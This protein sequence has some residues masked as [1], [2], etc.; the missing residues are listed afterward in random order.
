MTRRADLA[1]IHIAKKDLALD[2]DDYRGILKRV[3]GADSA[4]DLDAEARGRVIGYFRRLGWAP[5]RGTRQGR[6]PHGAPAQR[7]KIA[8]LLASDGLPP[9]YGEAIAERMH[10]K[11][12]A[13][14][15]P[16]E[17]RAVIASLVKQQQR[18]AAACASAD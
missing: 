5:R 18:R 12:L 9:E 6:E 13:F 4:A 15:S 16:A 10:G 7:R 14:C 11:P 1:K 2:E 3:G 17:L 8:A